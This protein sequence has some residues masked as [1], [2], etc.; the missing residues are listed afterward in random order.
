MS[1][2]G[3][4]DL[5]QPIDLNDPGASAFLGDL[6]GNILKS[7]GRR[8]TT[9]LFVTFTGEVADTKALLA[10]L[11]ADGT[12]TSAAEQ[13]KQRDRKEN[14]QPGPK[15]EAPGEET[16]TFLFLSAQGYSYI[17]ETA[18]EDEPFQKG[19]GRADADLGDPAQSAWD[20]PF[21]APSE[22]PIHALLILANE[23]SSSLD[24]A[25]SDMQERIVSAGIRVVGKIDGRGLKNGNGHDV[26]HFGYVDGISQPL[27]TCSDVQ[28]ASDNAT[29]ANAKADSLGAP[30]S[31]KPFDPSFSPE[32]T[33]LVP[34]PLSPKGGF[35]SFFV[36]R[37]LEQ[38]VDGF[39][40]AEAELGKLLP[41]GQEE[42]AG[43]MIVGRFEDG[44]PVARYGEEIGPI[45]PKGTPDNHFSYDI[46]P[47]GEKCPF[48]A[49]IRK[50]NPR[51]DVERQFGAGPEAER[52]VLFPRRGVTYGSR[53]THDDDVLN[54]DASHPSGGVGLLFMAYNKDIAR[55]F[56]FMQRDW[57]NSPTFVTGNP[58]IDPIIGQS[59]QSW[60]ENHGGGAKVVHDFHGFVRMK[61][62]E[63][64]FA[65]SLSGLQALHP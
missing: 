33:V 53:E 52:R 27:L 5:S 18:P 28:E 57:A 3:N 63:Y 51:G 26:E 13:K 1:E 7:H 59:G 4:L 2:V 35:G 25:A 32:A 41:K 29:A 11:A 46:D 16:A 50:T 6:Q 10:S 8:K 65:P 61:G 49:H 19:M 44:T 37:Q 39:K 55:Q 23:N 36:F 56:E 34:D 14:G 15:G 45:G 17:G 48:Q 12:I 62:G 20:E 60:P 54:E 22:A 58:G 21:N 43:A 31:V 40:K 30:K 42:R 47:D 38:N 9:N 64:F 24:K